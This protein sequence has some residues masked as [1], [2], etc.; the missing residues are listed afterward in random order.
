MSKLDHFG[1]TNDII[2]LNFFGGDENILVRFINITVVKNVI[3]G[4]NLVKI[5]NFKYLI[6]GEN[7]Q[8]WVILG[9]KIMSYVK[10]L[11]WDGN[12]FT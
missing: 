2:G 8:N 3:N 6:F 7:G 10:I 9:A 11:G 12:I 1:S 4:F 5:G